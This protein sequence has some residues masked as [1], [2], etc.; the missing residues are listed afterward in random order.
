MTSIRVTFRRVCQSALDQLRIIVSR[1]AII[2]SEIFFCFIYAREPKSDGSLSVGISLMLPRPANDVVG[3]QG[4]GRLSPASSRDTVTPARH[5]R[6]KLKNGRSFG[7]FFA[8][9]QDKLRE[10]ASRLNGRHV[11]SLLFCTELL[12]AARWRASRFGLD[13]ELVDDCAWKS[14]PARDLI[15][16][17]LTFL[18][19][20]LGA[21]SDWIDEIL[22]LALFLGRTVNELIRRVEPVTDLQPHFRAVIEKSKSGVRDSAGLSGAIDDPSV[23][24]PR[25]ASARRRQG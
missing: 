21:Q 5:P 4:I 25:L 11:V 16:T 6:E 9:S 14:V 18:R 17:M 8:A 1:W 15:E 22:N 24:R 20:A 23:R 3:H 13:G 10:L 12:H 7:R 19:P 2:A